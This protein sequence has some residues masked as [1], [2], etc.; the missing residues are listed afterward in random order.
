MKSFNFLWLLA[1]GLITQ[2]QADESPIEGYTIEE[3]SWEVETTPGGPTVVLNGTVEKVLS[4]LREIN[5]NYDTEFPTV[6]PEIQPAEQA[7]EGEDTSS[8]LVKRGDVVCGKFPSAYQSD[9][10]QGIKYLRTVPGKPQ[11]GPGPGSCGQVS[12]S[13]SSAIWWCNDNTFTKVLPSFNNIADGAQL[14]KN[15][16]LHG[17]QTFSGQDFHDDKWNTIVRFHKC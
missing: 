6:V 13:W 3:F 16:C 9:I 17:G 14:I 7:A 15:T 12:C 4:Q 8:H 1:A 5:P 11:R 2:V 10:D